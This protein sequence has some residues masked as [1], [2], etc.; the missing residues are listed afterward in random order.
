MTVA[1]RRSS[2]YSGCMK[3][4]RTQKDNIET[5]F[6][7]KVKTTLDDLIEL[8]NDMLVKFKHHAFNIRQQYRYS[9][10][11]KR[12]IAE[13]E[14]VIHVD[15]SENYICKYASEIQAMHFGV[16]IKQATQ[17]SHLHLSY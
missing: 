17:Q 2:P 16:Y 14:C 4:Q 3:A 6:K 7:K 10:E 1:K 15:F 12:N 5:T 11:L 13:N 8:F 9:R